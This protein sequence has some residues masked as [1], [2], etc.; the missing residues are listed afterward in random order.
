MW[1]VRHYELIPAANY[2]KDCETS[3][4][5]P[6]FGGFAFEGS[7]PGSKGG[8]ASGARLLSSHQSA[9]PVRDVGAWGM[10]GL[11]ATRDARFYV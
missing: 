11:L 8:V 7:R 4:G 1:L 2:E 6:F 5:V 9:L 3:D 10:M